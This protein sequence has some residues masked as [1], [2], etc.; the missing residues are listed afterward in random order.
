MSEKLNTAIKYGSLFQKHILDFMDKLIQT[1]P[2]EFE[3]DIKTI[4][5]KLEPFKNENLEHC[6]SLVQLRRKMTM[7][8]MAKFL[9]NIMASRDLFDQNNLDLFDDPKKY[10]QLPL[11]IMVDFKIDFFK[12]WKRPAAT[13]DVRKSILVYIKLLIRCADDATKVFV[14]SDKAKTAIQ[15]K[16]TFRAYKRHEM[17]KKIYEL[18]GAEGR[19]KS[20]DIVIDSILDE[21]ERSSS[22][23]KNGDV[24]PEQV[25]DMITKVY[26]QLSK[27]YLNGELDE[28]ELFKSSKL[29]YK[30]VVKNS[31]ESLGEHLGEITEILNMEEFDEEKIKKMIENGELTETLEKMGLNMEDLVNR[32][33]KT[34][35][36][37]KNNES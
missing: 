24:D 33:A 1:F 7:R 30:N 12:L 37:N 10:P 9:N 16:K 22:F 36:L 34:N 17:K 18:L 2:A 14:L 26:D 15:R 3:S 19:N 23:I 28:A 35:N 32:V 20:I 8:Y 13:D 21:F 5:N 4:I 25:Q 6:S 31:E 27:K 11:K 29:L